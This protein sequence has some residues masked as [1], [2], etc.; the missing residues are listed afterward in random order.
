MSFE[1]EKP[2]LVLAWFE[3]TPWASNFENQHAD[4][5]SWVCQLFGYGAEWNTRVA[6]SFATISRHPV[7]FFVS[8]I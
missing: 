4:Q 3:L 6:F 1:K 5:L 2:R 8:N 7:I